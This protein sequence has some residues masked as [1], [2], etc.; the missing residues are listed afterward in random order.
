MR[1]ILFLLGFA[2]LVSCGSKEAS[3]DGSGIE[4]KVK[5]LATLKTQ[6]KEL[7]AKVAAVWSRV[8]QTWSQQSH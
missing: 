2:A 3:A 7:A 6:Q 4:A 5:E 1:T 8:D